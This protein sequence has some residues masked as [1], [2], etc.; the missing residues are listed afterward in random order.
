MI[1][2][3]GRG[4]P[5][6][7]RFAYQT[8]LARNPDAEELSVVQGALDR[9]VARYRS[10]PEA[11]GKLVGFGEAKAPKSV[12]AEEIAAYSHIANLILNLDE[13]ISRN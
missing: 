8:V 11:A 6:R 9:F 2:E 13:T 3:G 7:I 1:L 5:E 12:A 4:A 10:D